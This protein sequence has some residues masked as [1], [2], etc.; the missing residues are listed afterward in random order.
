MLGYRDEA[1]IC[2]SSQRHCGILRAYL[3]ARSVLSLGP[4]ATVV[5]S[6]LIA[7]VSFMSSTMLNAEPSAEERRKLSFLFAASSRHVAFPVQLA[8]GNTA[9]VLADLHQGEVKTLLSTGAHLLWPFLTTDGGR[10]IFVRRPYGDVARDEL[11][12]CDLERLVCVKLLKGSGEIASPIQISGG[13]VL[14]AF[15]SAEVARGERPRNDFWIVDSQGKN[16]RKLTHFDLYE[17]YSLSVSSKAVYFSAQ[18]SPA[19]NRLVP[20][21]DPIARQISNI[22]FLPFDADTPS[23]S[24]PTEALD[25]LFVMD[26]RSTRVSVSADEQVVAFLNADTRRAPYRYDLIVID[27]AP[28]SPSLHRIRSNG[29]GFSQP[30]IVG[31]A[32]V[33]RDVLEDRHLI[34]RIDRGAADAEVIGVISD[35]AIRASKTIEI[36][37]NR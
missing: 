24:V 27:Q 11:V 36:Q 28:Q 2:G 20:D 34:K 5:A 12:S 14:Y 22:F 33:A 6:I 23:I 31:N 16:N 17:L 9:I 13:N 18:G 32:T 30:I 21:S 26:G 19:Y 25:P 1:A 4:L 29:V 15:N 3:R 8:A 7:G 37:F 35:A 10:L